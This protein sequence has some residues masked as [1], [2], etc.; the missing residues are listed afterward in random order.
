MRHGRFRSGAPPWWPADEPWPP[1]RGRRRWPGGRARVMGGMIVFFVPLVFFVLF[2]AASLFARAALH[3]GGPPIVA[4][5]LT[6]AAWFL[7]VFLFAVGLGRVGS[8]VG[9]IVDAAERVADGDFSAR[10]DSRGPGPIRTVG[11]AFNTM[12]ER[13]AA[14]DR[15]R[16]ELMAEIAHELRTP[17]TVIQGK[18]EGLLDGLYPRD[19]NH[20]GNVLDEARV[21]ARLVEDLRTLANAAT[22]V[23]TLEKEP[24][25]L[26]MLA[27]DVVASLSAEAAARQVM[28]RM[29]TPPTLPA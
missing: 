23:L 20:L 21:L 4:Y 2:G 17:L 12:T 25:D 9:D 7:F 22:G 10:I 14:H 11:R 15:Q 5:G 28:V 6:V 24:T 18:L 13:L 3:W 27:G 29:E 26:A 1:A 16:R 19:D 8:P